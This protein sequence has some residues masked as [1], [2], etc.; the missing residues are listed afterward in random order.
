MIGAAIGLLAEG[1]EILGVKEVMTYAARELAGALWRWAKEKVAMY[2][3]SKGRE[4]LED[5]WDWVVEKV[6]GKRAL[7]W[8]EVSGFE[9]A[10][11]EATVQLKNRSLEDIIRLELLSTPAG[12]ALL[13]KWLGQ[14][15]EESGLLEA[16]RRW[17]VDA[18]PIPKDLTLLEWATQVAARVGLSVTEVLERRLNTV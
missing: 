5:A 10:Q 4:W 17:H 1:I 16:A 8:G 12:H 3:I 7:P 15:S 14:L 2:V 13:R 18:A 9:L 11:L 6:T